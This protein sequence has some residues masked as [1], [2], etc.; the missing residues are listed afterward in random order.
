VLH[1]SNDRSRRRARYGAGLALAAV[2]AVSCVPAPDPGPGTTTTT[3]TSLPPSNPVPVS[4]VQLSW[5]FNEYSKFGA[6]GPWRM[7]TSGTDVSL[8]I[9]PSDAV[10][11]ATPGLAYDD[12]RFDGGT[13]ELDPATG[14]ASI[15]WDTGD[16]VINAYPPGFGAPD[17]TF[18]DPILDI[19]RDG[20]GTLSFDVSMPAGIDMAGNPTEPAGPARIVVATFDDVDQLGTGSL[21]ITPDFAGRSY[22][23]PE[24]GEQSQDCDGTGGSWP[25]EF[26]DFVA[27]AVRQHYYSTS[28]AGLNLLKQPTPFTISWEPSPV[29]FTRQPTVNTP[30]LADAGYDLAV[31]Y[32]SNPS[33]AVRWQLSTDGTTWTDVAASALTRYPHRSRMT[34]DN[35]SFRAVVTD[36]GGVE[37]VSAPA[38][39]VDVTGTILAIP[40]TFQPQDTYVFAGA[41][42][43][44]TVTATGS[45]S[46]TAQWQRSND[47][48]LTWFDIAGT[49]T[50]GNDRTNSNIVL[51]DVQL[52]DHG[53]KFRVRLNN[54]NNTPADLY[55]RVATLTVLERIEGQQQVAVF[56]T[57]IDTT[58]QTTIKII[59]AG[60]EPGA[61]QGNLTIALTDTT[62][63]Q[64]GQPS[65]SLG[66]LRTTSVTKSRIVNAG[67]RINAD[68]VL[69]AGQSFDPTRSYGVA[70]MGQ[71]VTDRFWD[72]WI[73]VTLTGPAG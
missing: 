19:E 57:T 48:G 63:W 64:P 49:T 10:G 5:T 14:E 12:V 68:L 33:P 59:G 31:G 34:D 4:G 1:R 11:S 18:T 73:P 72:R 65:V 28:C 32:T 55:S 67:G 61:G 52:A 24:S 29:T 9:T 70:L 13:G 6:V 21:S 22:T 58:N 15:A 30:L 56:P 53:A 66:A 17:E 45:P 38:G 43:L 50:P 40:D 35:A 37:H 25:K 54:G 20:S 2:C 71:T 69:P 42:P 8:G 26:I 51:T 16:F 46:G 62:R 41:S 3:T 39:P 44:I 36:T 60:F 47:G 7:S 27:L 23:E